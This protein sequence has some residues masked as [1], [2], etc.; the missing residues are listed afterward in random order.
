M[1]GGMGGLG[2]SGGNGSMLTSPYSLGGYN[3]GGP[4]VQGW[5]GVGSAGGQGLPGLGQSNLNGSAMW[6]KQFGGY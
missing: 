3:F 6:Q 4:G 5:N 1:G 2:V